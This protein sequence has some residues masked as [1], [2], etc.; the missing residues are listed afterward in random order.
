MAL[1]E[2]LDE[3]VGHD[4]AD[5]ADGDQ[6]GISLRFAIRG[7]THAGAQGVERAEMAR[8][9]LAPG[10]ADMRDAE[11]VDEAVHRNASAR[12][13]CGEEVAHARLAPALALLE[14]LGQAGVA[15]LQGE[16]VLRRADEALL[17]ELVDALRPESLD[18]E[19]VARYEMLQPLARLRRAD[20]PAGAAA[21]RVFLAG[22][23]VELAHRMAAAGRAD[24]RELVGPR[25]R[26]ALLEHDL[27]DLRD[28]VAGAL[29]HDRIA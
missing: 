10:L 20:E 22:A 21:H 29:H 3:R 19:G 24:R 27:E 13:D 26:R 5:T 25:V 18:V 11:R 8:E 15:A 17:V 2:E 4:L 7:R 12:L 16:D 1:L 28:D 9:Q 14:P 23:R 6:L